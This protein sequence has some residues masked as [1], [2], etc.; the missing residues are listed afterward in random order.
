MQTF[1][2][3]PSFSK[4]MMALDDKRLGNQVYNE[5]MVI[6][7]QLTECP[8]GYTDPITGKL[9]R[10]WSRHPAVKMWR[11]Y[12]DALALYLWA[13]VVEL[14]RRGKDYDDRPWCIE[15]R[16]K[17]THSCPM[18]PWLGDPEFHASHRS[19]LLRKDPVWYGQWDWTEPDDLEYVWPEV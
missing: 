8:D 14:N 16:S 1:L 17:L 12:E 10:G 3:Y 11:G 19:N 2:P 13:G 4:S 15:L 18:P 5:G 7:R 6:L 9:K